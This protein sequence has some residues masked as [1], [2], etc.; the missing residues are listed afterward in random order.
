MALQ[1]Q[2]AGTAPFHSPL[3]YPG[4]KR[5]LANF[6]GLL[7]R[8]NG[9]L[10]GDYAEVYAGGGA[11]AL[12]LLYGDYAGHIHLNDIDPGIYAFWVACRDR[13]DELCR[14]VNDA[15]LSLLEWDRQ[16][17]I[18]DADD[19]DPLDLAFSTL[20]LNRTNRS[21]IIAGGI[22]GG[23][24]QIGKWKMD[25]RFNRR[26]LIR[27][28]E[29]IGRWNSRISIHKLDGAEF[30]SQTAANLGP[31]ALVYLDPPYYLKGQKLYTNHYGPKDHKSVSEIVQKL[32]VPWVVSYDDHPEV[33]ALYRGRRLVTCDIS[34]GASAIRT[35]GREVIFFSDRLAIPDVPDP[36]RLSVAQATRVLRVA[37]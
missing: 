33:R 34:Y 16:R 11:V 26:D 22:I 8:T 1:K 13:T 24:Q 12:T 35:R 28:I 6:M 30:L 3:R 36:A 32:P 14:L 29:R 37:G 31:K 21:G 4:G 18:Q 7:F 19:P 27:R 2:R 9:L 17:S 15:P 23:R 5:K 10:D 25:A 20:Y